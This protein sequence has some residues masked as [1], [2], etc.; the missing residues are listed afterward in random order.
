MHTFIR[1]FAAAAC[2]FAALPVNAARF[3]YPSEEKE[4]FTVD[5]PAAWKP[6]VDDDGTLEAESPDEDA[7]LAFWTLES[8]DEIKTLDKDIEKWMK[9]DLKKIKMGEKSIEKKINGIEFT[10]FN[11]TAISKE[12][13]SKVAFEI[14]LFSPKAGK[15]GVFYCQ[16][17]PEAPDSIKSLI[18]IVESIQKK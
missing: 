3:S 16:Y 7:Y 18:K 12:D 8:E 4:W 14:F 6:E 11:G 13:D 5:I 10:I 2:L 9:G 17:D 1:T 15:L